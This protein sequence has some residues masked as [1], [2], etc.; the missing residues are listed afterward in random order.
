MRLLKSSSS[1]FLLSACLAFSAFNF[2]LSILNPSFYNLL[3][4]FH[5]FGKGF[6]MVFLVVVIPACP[7]SFSAFRKDSRRVS[8]AGMTTYPFAVQENKS[9]KPSAYYF[10]LS[11]SPVISLRTSSRE[12][13]LA[14]SNSSGV[15]LCSG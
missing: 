6:C 4:H 14:G 5:P 11:I 13:I 10:S 1:F 15:C 2:N 8:L 7:E 3:T 9:A 12:G